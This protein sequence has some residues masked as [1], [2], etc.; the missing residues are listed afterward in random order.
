MKMKRIG[1]V[2]AGLWLGCA[3]AS[4]QQKDPSAEASSAEASL[5]SQ[6]AVAEAQPA[7]KPKLIC[8]DVEV[9]G[10]HL[11]QRICRTV[12]QAKA[13]RDQAQRTMQEMPKVNVREGN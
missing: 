8:E 2:V 5:E 7:Q 13:D 9:T 4:S 1:W 12:E 11:K 10:S 3:T 6:G